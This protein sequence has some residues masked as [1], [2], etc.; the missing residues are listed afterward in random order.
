MP[1]F[2][3]HATAGI[4]YAQ[5]FKRSGTGTLHPGGIFAYMNMQMWVVSYGNASW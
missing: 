2:L 5:L 4:S 1:W 3:P